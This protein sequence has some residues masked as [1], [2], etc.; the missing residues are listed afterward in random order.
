MTSLSD[1][2]IA[3]YL[4]GARFKSCLHPFL[5]TKILLGF[6]D[7]IP[8]KHRAPQS[9]DLTNPS[10]LHLFGRAR[11]ASRSGSVRNPSR[12]RHRPVTGFAI[13]QSSV[14]FCPDPPVQFGRLRHRPIVVLPSSGR[15]FGR[16]SF[17]GP[18]LSGS[19]RP[20]LMRATSI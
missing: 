15:R 4:R 18:V 12:F 10:N 16:V 20:K 2:Y 7:Q 13:I 11:S 8:L 3:S 5:C 14:R 17:A 6:L 9:T 1:K 19:A